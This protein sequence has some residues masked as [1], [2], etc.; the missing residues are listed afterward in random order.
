MFVQITDV[1]DSIPH[2]EHTV[3]AGSIIGHQAGQGVLTVAGV[4]DDEY[5]LQQVPSSTSRG[6][7]DIY[8]PAF[9]SRTKPDLAGLDCVK[10]TSAGGVH[11]TVC[12]ASV[13]AARVAGIAALLLEANPDLTV[14]QVSDVLTSTATDIDAANVDVHPG[15][16]LVDAVA[17]LNADIVLSN[18]TVAGM[19]RSRGTAPSL[20][21]F[22]FEA[23]IPS[24][25]DGS[26]PP[27]AGSPNYF[28]RHRDDEVHNPGANNPSN[29]FLEIFE[30]HTDFAT[31]ANSTFTGPTQIPITDIDSDLCGLVSFACFPQPNTGTTL[32]PLREVIMWRL[33]YRNFGTHETLVGNFVTDVDG[34]DHGGIRWFELRKTGGGPG[35]CTRRGRLP[36]TVTTGGWVVSPWIR[37]ETLLWATV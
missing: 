30:F 7:S 35:P 23:L 1:A 10:L 26:T 9:E 33:Q 24:D 8:H 17:A 28:M 36:P 20:G 34:T 6:P 4:R 32:D 11:Q 12:G 15:L 3:V 37:T 29:D 27:P 16:G 2:H 19:L 13:A 25:L 22:V 31:P 14:Q 21:A 18:Q 5:G